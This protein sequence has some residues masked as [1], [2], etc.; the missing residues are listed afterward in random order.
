MAV[1]YT[2]NS[3]S[4]NTFHSTNII[5]W[6]CNGIRPQFEELKIL[7]TNYCPKT[8]CLQETHLKPQINFNLRS[9]T[10]YRKDKIADGHARGG[11]LTA[12]QS[13]TYSELVDLDTPLQAVAVRVK[14]T[15]PITIC[16]LYLPP[17]E[18]ID[19]AA[20]YRLIFSLPH[21]YLIVGD[22]NGNHVSWGASASNAR[23]TLI[24]RII[25]DTGSVVL[26]TNKA[27]FISPQYRTPSYIDLAISS[28]NISS[29]LAWDVCSDQ[30]GS[31]HFPTI[32]TYPHS[33]Q[34]LPRQHPRWITD[35]ADWARF[36]ELAQAPQDPLLPPIDEAITRFTNTII[37]AAEATI[38]RTKGLPR[39]NH[40]PWF[41]KDC[42]Q[43]IR[44]RNKALRHFQNNPT[45]PNYVAYKR[46]K[47]KARHIVKTKRKQCWTKYLE[48]IN[49]NTPIR[50]VWRKVNSVKGAFQT[51]IPTIK[52][53]QQI[54]TEAPQVAEAFVDHFSSISNS[55]PPDPIPNSQTSSRDPNLNPYNRPFS[56]WELTSAIAEL[57][58]S[59]PGPDEIH[60]EMI[61]HLPNQMK[62]HLLQ[63]YNKIWIEGC[64]PESWRVSTIIPIPKPGK[65]QHDVQ[66][67]RPISLTSCLCKLLEKMVNKRLIWFLERSK[68]LSNAQCGFRKG[69]STLDHLSTIEAEILNAFITQEEVL[70]ILF[71]IEKAY[72]T[73]SRA[74]IVNNLSKCR[75]EGNMLNFIK[76]FLALRKV[77]VRVGHCH[78]T[79]RNI[80][81]GIPQGSVLSCTLFTVGINSVVDCIPRSITKT[82]FVD[83]LGIFIRFRQV[84]A[85]KALTQSTL[86]KLLEWA[87]ANKI[88][89][90]VEKTKAILFSRKRSPTP[91]PELYM[92]P[93]RLNYYEEAKFLGLTLDKKLTWI[94]HIRNLKETCTQRLRLMRVLAGTSW[95][96]DRRSMT[97]VYTSLIRSKLDYGSPVYS[98][99][100]SS[101]LLTLD[102]VHHQ[103]IRL[104]T[105][106][107]KSSPKLSLCVD[108]GLPPLT[109]RRQQLI[110]SY[111]SQLIL[112]PNNPSYNLI[113][114]PHH[115][116]SYE[117][118]PRSPAP[119]GIRQR[120]FIRTLTETI[121]YAPPTT[122]SFPPWLYPHPVIDV[123]LRKYSKKNTP[124]HETI[125]AFRAILEEDPTSE[126]IYT[127]GSKQGEN[128][129]LSVVKGDEIYKYKLPPIT[130]IFT[131]EMQ[132]IAVALYRAIESRHESFLI[133][134]DSYS[135]ITCLKNLYK[136]NLSLLKIRTYLVTLERQ[137]KR[138]RFLWVPSHIGIKGNEVADKAAKE[139]AL[140]DH[141]NIRVYERQD[142]KCWLRTLAHREWEAL[143]QEVAPTTKLGMI[144][145]ITKP[146][147]SSFR[148]NRREEVVLTRL[149]IGHCRLTHGFLMAN[150]DPP[151]CETCGVQKSVKHL[152]EECTLYTNNF[153]AKGLQRSL[154]HLLGD[155][156]HSVDN[157]LLILKECGI[158]PEI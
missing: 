156:T 132:A 102:S 137:Q 11:V 125:T 58:S 30:H 12:V 3:H 82:L 147:R 79:T 123:R 8:I 75:L 106:A 47:A 70:G 80:L 158:F 114:Y 37:K 29:R 49:S 90:S 122:S 27:T 151:I 28:P 43:A 87:Q 53:D 153:V 72:D 146:W 93:Q 62:D 33:S 17:S 20:V 26:N 73:I 130:S 115:V 85:L 76:N 78:S 89:F 117:D 69:R 6:N 23:G 109:I 104:A 145:R 152:L 105:G 135:S 155:N 133:C 54:I 99:A 143:W 71:D 35:E 44:E 14:L 126:V 1:Q 5:S 140:G 110:S 19:A 77:K 95:G 68:F 88:K 94:S 61:K 119:L 31:D 120:N 83:D 42:R 81:N 128:V 46:E 144:K 112:N 64:F 148:G 38:P 86:N 141:D 66:N 51:N 113:F 45:S 149:R 150:D 16:N 131:A 101:V 124:P 92:G 60:N 97:T 154:R 13:S 118:K 10:L 34:T 91:P 55:L 57:K 116:R 41:D 96:A 127:D 9:Y 67:F 7:L 39:H 139:A 2:N 4:N 134:S 142:I 59:A 22:L 56:L 36:Q 48:T 24:K 25:D 21:P 98:S 136:D 129:G 18:Q 100:K 111:L 107:F 52:Q 32:I 63:L 40:T 74:L 108:S 157:L 103:G 15:F 138:I 50:S 84:E 65:D 121:Q